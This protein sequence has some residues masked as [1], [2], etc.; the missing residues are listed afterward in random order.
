MN[1]HVKD[2]KVKIVFVMYAKNDS[3]IPTRSLSGDLH[4]KHSKKI[5]GESEKKGVRDDVLS[6][7]NY[8]IAVLLT[9]E[10]YNIGR[11]SQII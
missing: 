2:G 5:K 1:N 8:F 4:E 10:L 6:S 9:G 7:N 11:S 3:D